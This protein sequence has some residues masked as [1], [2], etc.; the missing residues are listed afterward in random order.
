MVSEQPI[1]SLCRLHSCQFSCISSSTSLISVKPLGLDSPFGF[2]LAQ[3]CSS[4]H[5]AAPFTQIC[6]RTSQHR[7]SRAC[8]YLFDRL[9][10]PAMIQPALSSLTFSPRSQFPCR[11]PRARKDPIS[12]A[13]SPDPALQSPKRW[14]LSTRSDL[15]RAQTVVSVNRIPSSS[16]QFRSSQLRCASLESIMCAYFP[17][18]HPN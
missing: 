10:L 1:S 6:E 8:F 15:H 4:D 9:S 12:I 11:F 18:N 17:P 7:C 14:S 5:R 13:L 2:V 3:F 16:A